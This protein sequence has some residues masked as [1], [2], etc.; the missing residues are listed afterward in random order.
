M[1]GLVGAIIEN[2]IGHGLFLFLYTLAGI[3]GNLLSMAYEMT[4]DVLFLI[5]LMLLKPVCQ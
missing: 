1:L 4:N 3:A 2:Y 5:V